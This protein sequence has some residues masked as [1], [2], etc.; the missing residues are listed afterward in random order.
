MCGEKVRRPNY[1]QCIYYESNNIQTEIGWNWDWPGNGSVRAYPE[2]I[3]GRKPWS[4]ESTSTLLPA[5]INSNQITL[6]YY[7]HCF[8]N[9]SMESRLRHLA[10]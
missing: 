10:Y 7:R 6:K 8:G 5:Q 3:F 2:I 4:T 1:E 9:W